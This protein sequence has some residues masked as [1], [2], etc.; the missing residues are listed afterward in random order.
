MLGK[1]RLVIRT[2]DLGADKISFNGAVRERNPLLGTRAIRLCFEKKDIFKAQLAGILKVSA[3]GN[4]G[5]MFP[6]ISSYEDLIEVKKI[7]QEVKEELISK[8]ES[9][10]QDIEIGIMI[11][12]PSAAITVD[13]LS[14]EVD[15]LSIGTNDLIAF[16]MAADR[17][18]ERVARFYQ[19]LHPAVLRL[20]KDVIDTG[21]RKKIPV[22]IC[23]EMASN[24]SYTL[25]LVG[26]G[27]KIFSVVPSIIPELKKIIRSVS[28]SEAEGIA[29]RALTFSDAEKTLEYLSTQTR[30]FLPDL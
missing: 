10:N 7:F 6:M 22:S 20:L 29:K 18:N 4:V 30:N 13:I 12:I 17:A 1:K 19:P 14:D 2:L 3:I 16:L 9:F 15:F 23:G 24:I 27:L 21:A 25:L 28:M 11:E 5:V 8:N 26:L